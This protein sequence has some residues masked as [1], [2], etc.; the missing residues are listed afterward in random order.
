MRSLLAMRVR[1]YLQQGPGLLVVIIGAG[2]LVAIGA[3]VVQQVMPDRAVD[4][5]K[6][7]V[8]SQLKSPSSADFSEVDSYESGGGRV[9]FG[10]VDSENGFGASIR[11]HFRC[12]VED[13]GSWL[14]TDVDFTGPG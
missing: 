5:C 3:F 11:N 10:E 8:L 7:E 14:V 9:V 1:Y 12:E 4:S 13:G 6:E 2:L